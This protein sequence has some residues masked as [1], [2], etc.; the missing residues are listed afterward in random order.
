MLTVDGLEKIK[1]HKKDEKNDIID[2]SLRARYIYDSWG[3]TLSVQDGN[4]QEITSAEHIANLNPFRYRGYYFDLETG[5]Y[6]L[7]NRY[8]DPQTC[9]FVNGDG[10]VSTG[11]GF[12]GNNMFAYCLNSPVQFVDKTGTLVA[13]ANAGGCYNPSTSNWLNNAWNS[14]KKWA[15]DT[16]GA[17]YSMTATIAKKEVEYLPDPLPITAKTGTKTTHTISEYGNSSKPVSVYAER[18]AN[19]PIKSSSVGI[20]INASNFTLD[21][22][23]GLDNTGVSGSLTKGNTTNTFGIKA[24]LSELKLGFESSSAV[25]WDNITET[26]YANASISGW[27]AVAVYL[28]VTTGQPMPTPPYAYGY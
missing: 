5:L 10:Y 13:L 16:F 24:N 11:Q 19:H 14:V 2:G 8:Y 20:K 18:D 12:T 17:G 23:L 22:S 26:T 6:Y 4:G 28:L 9:R 7:Q 1:G 27:A 3:N 25:Q 21:I 15:N